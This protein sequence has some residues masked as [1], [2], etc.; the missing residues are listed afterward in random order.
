MSQTYH[1]MLM[2]VV[3]ATKERRPFLTPDIEPHLYRY[4]GSAIQNDFGYLLRIGGTEDHVHILFNMKPS[5][6]ASNALRDIK[7]Y[8]SGWIH[9]TYRNM[10]DF[11][12]QGGY[13]IFSVSESRKQQVID[14]INDQRKHHAK[15]DLRQEMILLLRRNG[16]EYD[17][18]YLWA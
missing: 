5:V 15:M 13:G 4:I 9:K 17:E 3:F 7:A 1:N 12:W 8:S 10:A 11:S 14:Y 6:S 2:H 16:I 18:K